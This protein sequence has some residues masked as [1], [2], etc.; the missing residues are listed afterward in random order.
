MTAATKRSIPYI[1]QNIL[2][3]FRYLEQR[4]YAVGRQCRV[5]GCACAGEQLPVRSLV[6][7]G[8]EIQTLRWHRRSAAVCGRTVAA[9]RIGHCAR[10]H[11]CGL[12]ALS[13]RWSLGRSRNSLLGCLLGLLVWRLLLLLLLSS[14]RW[15]ARIL[16]SDG[17]LKLLMIQLLLVELLLLLHL[18]SGIAGSLRLQSAAGHWHASIL[19]LHRTWL[20]KG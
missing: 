11:A 14:L 9:Q 3:K 19:R 1:C 2:I 4:D 17:L 16:R 6:V 12:R 7:E 20:A 15:I 13:W 18:L 8:H 5:F 10:G